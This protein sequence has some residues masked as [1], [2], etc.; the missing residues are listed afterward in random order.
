MLRKSFLVAAF[1]VL[2]LSFC[3]SYAAGLEQLQW[4]DLVNHPERWPASTTI[5]VDLEFSHANLPKGTKV[6]IS[7]VTANQVELIAPQGFLFDLK[8]EE[9]NL[10][11]DANA[12]W[13]TLTPA[14][15]ELNWQKISQDRTLWPSYISLTS[16]IGFGQVSFKEGDTLELI[17]IQG[18]DVAVANSKL[19]STLLVS[20]TDTDIFSRARKMAALPTDQRPGIISTVL[21]G[22][23]I[24]SDGNKTDLAPANYYVMYYAASTCPRCKIFSPEFVDFYNKN[25]A[26]RKDVR[27]IICSTDVNKANIWPYMKQY[28][29]PWSTLNGEKADNIVGYAFITPGTMIEIPGIIVLDRFGNQLL[30]TKN[31]VPGKL[32]AAAETAMG[33]LND[34]LSK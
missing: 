3:V 12:F 20:N 16:P 22:R 15:K 30:A 9:C 8:P 17:T 10:L 6:Q 34:L 28:G 29:I 11:A 32:I 18:N 7:N 1:A 21:K 24:D 31:N 33:Q 27:F 4:R 25:F 13:A 26:D 19:E 2:T 23:T 14:Q 5:K